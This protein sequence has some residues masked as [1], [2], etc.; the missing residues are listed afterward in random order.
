MNDGGQAFP[1]MEKNNPQSCTAFDEPY[2][3]V[4]G[5]SLR[6][7]FAAKA[8]QGLL[9]N[10][11]LSEKLATL[12]THMV[13]HGMTQEEVDLTVLQPTMALGSYQM[14]DAMIAAREAK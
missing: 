12:K 11:Y 10:S 4:S 5:M 8:L 2:S 7:Y 9:S 13:D 6:D 3:W 14:A 1:G